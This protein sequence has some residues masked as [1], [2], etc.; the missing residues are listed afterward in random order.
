LDEIS[1]AS[2]D[3]SRLEEI[4]NTSDQALI[5]KWLWKMSIILTVPAFVLVP[6]IIP[7]LA[8]ILPPAI[9]EIVWFISKL[10]MA[11]V[12]IMLGLALYLT[13]ADSQ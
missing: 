8:N 12:L 3:I 9:Y 1:K 11:M 6:F 7:S 13:K 2:D 10:F 4:E 5:A